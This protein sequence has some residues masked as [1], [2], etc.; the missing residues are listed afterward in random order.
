MG[1]QKKHPRCDDCDS[2]EKE[3]EARRA[4]NHRHTVCETVSVL[5]IL[6]HPEIQRYLELIVQMSA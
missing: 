5:V 4:R 6:A 1:R 2:R 3:Q